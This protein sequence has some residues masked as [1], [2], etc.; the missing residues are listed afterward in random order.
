MYCAT[1]PNVFISADRACKRIT[2]SRILIRFS[3]IAEANDSKQYSLYSL[4]TAPGWK[5]L[6]KLHNHQSSP[7]IYKAN[8]YKRLR[9]TNW[10]LACG[11]KCTTPQKARLTGLLN[12]R[13]RTTKEIRWAQAGVAGRRTGRCGTVCNR[14]REDTITK[15]VLSYF[16]VA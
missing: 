12:K 15:S 2:E 13:T 10:L 16:N 3:L 8:N 7:D 9:W 4:H 5:T 14:H 11:P 6:N 1:F